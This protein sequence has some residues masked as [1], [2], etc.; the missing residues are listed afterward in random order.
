MPKITY[1][2]GTDL[3]IIDATVLYW[4]LH[5]VPHPSGTVPQMAV[6][7]LI[8]T[9]ASHVV[10]KPHIVTALG[11]PYACDVDNTVVGGTVHKVPAYAGEVI[12]GTPA[13]GCAVPD[14]LMLSQ[15]L[16]AEYD[17]IIGWGALSRC[18]WTFDRS[19]TFTQSW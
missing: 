2:R 10:V 11:L 5:G 1:N 15:S 3:P 14:M 12:M 13:L 18:D 8:D 19:G 4:P 16:G 7:A 17:I 9:G 6:R